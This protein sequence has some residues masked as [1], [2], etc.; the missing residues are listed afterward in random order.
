MYYVLEMNTKLTSKFIYFRKGPAGLDIEAWQTGNKFESPPAALTMEAEDEIP[1][2]LSDLLLAKVE[3]HVCSPKL[4]VTLAAAGV[5]NIEYFPVTVVDKKRGITRTDYRAANILGAVA[6]L[7]VDNSKVDTFTNGS[8]Y[9]SVEEFSLLEDQIKPL[10]SMK[11]PPLLFRLAEFTYHVIAHQSL[12]DAF[13]R[14][15]IT[16]AR[17]IPTQDYG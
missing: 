13:E 12:K 11:S 8:G 6:C 14:D 2:E 17:F 7:D 10:P 3:L 16:G 5:T 4:M 15:G 1:S 9:S